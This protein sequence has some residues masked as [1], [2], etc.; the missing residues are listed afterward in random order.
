MK[1]LFFRILL[2]NFAVDFSYAQ[3]AKLLSKMIAKRPN[4]AKD[5][6]IKHVEFAIEF[7]PIPN[8]DPYGRKMSFMSYYML[9]IIIPFILL[10]LTVLA[11]LC[12]VFYKI[13]RKFVLQISC[14]SSE[15]EKEKKNK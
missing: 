2:L 1:L 3:K 10:V 11:A 9:D 15:K 5:Q 12:Y 13:F 14:V 8:F 7:G 4:S 6:L